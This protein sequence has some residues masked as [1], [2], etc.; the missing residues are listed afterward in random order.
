MWLCLKLGNKAQSK[1]D[2]LLEQCTNQ[3]EEKT[4]TK[5]IFCLKSYSLEG[6]MFKK[7][8]GKE[9]SIQKVLKEPKQKIIFT[10]RKAH[11]KWA[12]CLI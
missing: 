5:N 8:E 3:S 1:Q 4:K 10:Q 9:F 12:F 2:I 6:Y 11:D 7:K